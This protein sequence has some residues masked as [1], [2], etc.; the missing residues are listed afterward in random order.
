MVVR[1]WVD[2]V[3]EKVKNERL[4]LFGWKEKEIWGRQG[5][6]TRLG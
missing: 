3:R 5:M 1:G 6:S 2:Q 4:D